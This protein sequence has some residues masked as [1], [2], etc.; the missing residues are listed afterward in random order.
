MAGACLDPLRPRDQ[1]RRDSEPGILCLG[2]RKPAALSKGVILRLARHA[3][4]VAAVA[5]AGR[6]EAQEP[7]WTEAVK[8]FRI[9]PNVY[10]VGSK[11]LSAYLITSRQGAILIDGTVAGNAA[12]IERNIE[13]VG[14]P[15][16]T[17]KWI[18]SDHAHYDHVGAVAKI[19]LDTGARFA[20]SAGDAVALQR[21]LPRG[22]TNYP[23]TAFPRIAI[24]WVVGDGE[25]IE[26]GG[27]IL[28]AHLTPGHT[29]GCT[30]W[31]TRVKDGDRQLEVL[32]LCSITV[33]GNVLVGNQAYPTIVADF[34]KTFAQL[35]AMKA[36]IVLTSHPGVADVLGREA[37]VEAGDP[38]AFIDPKELPSI[39]AQSKAEFEAA[40][41]EAKGGQAHRA[42][43]QLSAAVLDSV[44]RQV[45][46]RE[47]VVGASVLVARRGSVILHR[48]YGL[49]DLEVGA[50]ARDETVYHVVGPM[51]PFTGIAV[52]QQV[53]RGRLSLDDDIGKYV[54]EFPMQGYHVT[55]RQLLNHTSGIVDY[56]YLGDPIEATSRQPKALD[57][58]MA[59]YAG[60]GWLNPPGAKWDWSISGF[61]LLVTIVERV[62]GQSFADYV[63]D[64]ILKPAGV[65]STSY[66]DEDAV[67]PGLAHAYRIRE[68]SYAPAN[69]TDMAYN[70]DLR[71]CSTVG[72]LYTLWTAIHDK[73]LIRPESFA[74][75]T[76]AEGAAAHMSPTDSLAQYGFAVTI[77]HEDNHRR[78]GQ[79]GSLLGYSGSLYDF[80]ND[81]LT[82]VVLTNTENQNAYAITRAIARA[83]LGLPEL[84]VPATGVETVLADVPVDSVERRHLSGTFVLKLDRLTP[85]LHDS[86]A[87]YRRTYRVFD[88]NGRLMIEALGESPR[89]LLKQPDGSFATRWAPRD[90]I[91]FVVAG[92]HVTSMHLDS[93]A[94]GVPLSGDRVGD[95]DP[96]TFHNQPH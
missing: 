2:R 78:I 27:A 9:A 4:L 58:V 31:S 6:L 55:I 26:V 29:P 23:S 33:A 37:R 53:E 96:Q 68:H 8:P 50:P 19:K 91:T 42:A 54:P 20:S 65:Q 12:L 88:E 17:V 38:G 66:C 60:K 16:K 74:K 62:T 83:A 32:F 79:H 14:V 80:P 36:D 28:T 76:T 59:L 77:N 44:A 81:S 39:V 56:H 94:F 5:V 34:E 30:S 47:H 43:A 82:V 84:P 46:A 90:R 75:M 7:D 18:V 63:R 85:G 13:A 11:G 22:D 92:D 21:G 93:S 86:F 49:A 25:S 35:S 67:V 95:G 48:G 64:Q 52:L 15:L 24:D 61:S 71:F 72:D 51:L 3:V 89:R 45:I 69:E 41:S 10:Y 70:A 73:G 57:E 40:L 1:Y 87:Q